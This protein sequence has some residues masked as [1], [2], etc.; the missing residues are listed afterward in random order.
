MFLHPQTRFTSGFFNLPHLPILKIFPLCFEEFHSHS[1]NICS[2]KQK[3]A[4]ILSN[5]FSS[6][7]LCFQ[8]RVVS[9]IPGVNLSFP[10]VVIKSSLP[11]FFSCRMFFT[12]IRKDARVVWFWKAPLFSWENN[13]FIMCSL[14]STLQR[15]S[16]ANEQKDI[17]YVSAV[18]SFL[19]LMHLSVCSMLYLLL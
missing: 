4:P 6:Y 12:L 14:K 1:T 2:S 7:V 17:P 11:F 16:F 15:F 10:L 13:T 8:G 18:L 5:S 3:G 9:D 19:V